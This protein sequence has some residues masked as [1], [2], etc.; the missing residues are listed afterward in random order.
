MDRSP[1]L[2]LARRIA[3]EIR[4]RER[5]NLIAVGV[6]GSA[7]RGDDREFSDVDVLVVVRRKRAWIRHRI[8]D[9]IL[10]TFHQLTPAEAREE[11]TGSGPW[12]NGPLAGWRDTLALDDPTRLISRLRAR[13]WKPSAAQFRESARRDLL[14]LFERYGKVRNAIAAGDFEEARETASYFSDGAAGTLLDLEGHVPAPHR[15]YF[16]E[17]AR[18]GSVGR[19]IWRLRHEARTMP[20]ITRLTEQVWAGLLEKAQVQGIRIP[21][22]LGDVTRSGRGGPSRGR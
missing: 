11:A 14:E 4:E 9:G 8:R 20:A 1:R 16:L 5:A 22:L 13:A 3:R 17:V 10:V 7:A 12:L 2:A 18:L 6:Y 19:A 15:R 21:G